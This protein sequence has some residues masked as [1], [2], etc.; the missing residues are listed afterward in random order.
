MYTCSLELNFVLCHKERSGCLQFKING[1]PSQTIFSQYKNANI[2]KFVL[3]VPFQNLKELLSL[4][5]WNVMH[6]A[7]WHIILHLFTY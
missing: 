7:N 1:L 6:S 4:Q 3:A 2:A 5:P